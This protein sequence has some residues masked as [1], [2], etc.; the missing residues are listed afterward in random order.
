MNQVTIPQLKDRLRT[1][2]L[3]ISG[4]KA[5]LLTRLSQNQL[6]SNFQLLSI[7]KKNIQSMLKEK[8]LKSTGSKDE[9]INSLVGAMR[10]IKVTSTKS[11]TMK[12]KTKIID[13]SKKIREN[14]SYNSMK[15]FYLSLYIQNPNS[16]MAKQ[17][18]ENAQITSNEMNNYTK[19][20]TT[21]RK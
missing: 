1:R 7:S 11:E 14:K 15:K 13:K 16:K 18:K 8:G 21:R 12:P 9:L 17:W 3:K 4:T 6:V 2:G 10:K 19:N 5:E 20:Y